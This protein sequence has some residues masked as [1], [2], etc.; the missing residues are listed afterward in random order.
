MPGANQD[1]KTI[2]EQHDCWVTV[3]TGATQHLSIML[4]LRIETK[5]FFFRLGL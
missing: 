5:D 1:L 3:H 4:L 2:L